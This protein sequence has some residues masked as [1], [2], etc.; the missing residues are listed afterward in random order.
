MNR[1]RNFYAN[2][3]ETLKEEESY[4]DEDNYDDYYD[5]EYYDERYDEDCEVDPIE[6]LVREEIKVNSTTQNS[7]ANGTTASGVEE[8]GEILKTISNPYSFIF[9]GS[10]E[11]Y[12]I[13]AAMIPQL[14]ELWKH[15]SGVPLSEKDAIAGLRLH[16][17]DPDATAAYLKKEM[18]EKKKMR[19]NRPRVLRAGTETKKNQTGLEEQNA[20]SKETALSPSVSSDGQQ[21]SKKDFLETRRPTEEIQTSFTSH[22][23]SFPVSSGSGSL[24]KESMMDCTLIVAGHVDAGKSTILGHL[25][26]LL[27]RVSVSSPFS[28]PNGKSMNLPHSP[29][30]A[31]CYAHV[32]DQTEEERRRGMTMDVGTHNFETSHRRFHALDAPGH[33]DYIVSMMSGATQADAVLLIVTATLGEFEVGLNHGTKEHL[34]ILKILGVKKAIVAVNKMDM[35]GYSQERYN[36][37]VHKVKEL[38][39]KLQF[40][41]SCVAGVCPI[42]GKTGANMMS[43]CD[44]REE[45]PWYSGPSLLDLLDSCPLESRSIN[46]PLRISVQDINDAQLYAKIESGLLKKGD[47]VQFM[48]CGTIVIVKSI[49]KSGGGDSIAEAVAGEQVI[50]KL[51]A[52][53]VGLYA[54]CIGCHITNLISVSTDFEAYIQT[55]EMLERPLLPGS[56]LLLIAHALQVNIR[57]LR[58]VS[59]FDS[60]KGEGEWS[61]GMVKC[62]TKDREAKIVFRAD[63]KV[64]LEPAECCQSLSRIVLSQ[65]GNTVAGGSVL[66]V[67]PC[68]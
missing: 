64:A 57:I 25:L 24:K 58:L 39:S 32:L 11:D 28:K 18:E 20:S 40:P 7:T 51:A 46:G 53:P 4:D 60:S 56:S 22:Q 67:L 59:I 21:A 36:E 43:N 15:V 41:E 66:K 16:Q 61:T 23:P 44:G 14:D 13:L 38:F 12:E 52:S 65:D 62:I 49:T 10:D 8:C 35:V 55:I 31:P 1:H 17:Y 37:V 68:S 26:V 27:G 30:G 6:Q 5:E 9:P 47:K 42:S 54:G 34:E 29:N 48:P 63:T 33:K 19:G 45:M 3:A 50:L 2:L